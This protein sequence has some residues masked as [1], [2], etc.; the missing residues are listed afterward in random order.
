MNNKIQEQYEQYE[1][2]RSIAYETHRQIFEKEH[3]APKVR[4]VSRVDWIISV[5][6][7]LMVFSSVIV[8]G[9][10]TVVEF[11]GGVVGVMAFAMVELSIVGLS[12]FNTRFGGTVEDSEKRLRRVR[13][14]ASI[15]ILLSVV[16][17]VVANVDAV[18][19]ERGIYTAEE[20]ETI[21]LVLVAISAPTFAYISGHILAV[22][23]SVQAR[24]KADAETEHRAAM[25][26]WMNDLNAAWT[27]QRVNYGVRKSVRPDVQ[28]DAV[29]PVQ[30]DSGQ[31]GQGNRTASSG[32]GYSRMS[33]AVEAVFAH[34][35]AHPEDLNKPVR[36]LAE[37]IGVSKS[38]VGNARKQWEGREQDTP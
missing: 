27:R 17:A 6:L 21:I 24:R 34:W 37:I 11:G 25:E 20:V 9:S 28:I 7:I 31:I 36:E 35:A 33:N 22:V 23:F 8:S 38:T 12:F 16:I 18:L 19:S 5:S 30:L 4:S 32:Q 14:W 3:P 10:R 29:Q 13:T 1:M 26:Q 15:G 2:V